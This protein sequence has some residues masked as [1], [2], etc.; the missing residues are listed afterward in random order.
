MTFSTLTA[1]SELDLVAGHGRTAHVA[2]HLGVDVELLE[3]LGEALDHVVAGLGA[4]LVGRAR[5]EHV[6]GR[7]RVGDVA[8]QRELLD[9]GR[10]RGVRGRLELAG[11]VRVDDDGGHL[12]P[13]LGL[14]LDGVLLAALP[15]LAVL[16]D[17]AVVGGVAQL[18]AVEVRVGPTAPDRLGLLRRTGLGVVP[19]PT[20]HPV[21]SGREALRHAIKGRRGDHQH[22]EEGQQHQQ[23]HHDQVG[24]EQVEQQRGDDEADS[25]TALTQRSGVAADRLRAPVGDVDESEHA[26]AERRPADHLAS[27]GSVA[28]RVAHHAP[29]DQDH[30]Q[31]HQ[32]A[33]LADRAGHDGADELEQ[34]ARRTEP[35]RGGDHDRQA[36]EEEPS[37]VATVLGVEVAGGVP[38][39][40]CGGADTV[41]DPQ[42]DGGQPPEERVEEPRYR[43]G[44]VAHGSR[45][46]PP[47]R[48][49][50]ALAVLLLR[51]PGAVA[52]AASPTFRPGRGRA[53]APR[54]RRGR[55]T[56]RHGDHT[57]AL[58]HQSH[59]PHGA[60]RIPPVALDRRDR[61]A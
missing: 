35:D 7:E 13:G 55:R 1:G 58:S 51:T 27:S 42:P 2:G 5:L 6:V 59:A 18:E 29:A 44:P 43:A 36:E 17:R 50:S 16:Q 25:S 61:S 9:A 41:G 48:G 8:G 45:R 49:R 46:R 28:D 26:E 30:E 39:T 3:H 19:V 54:S 40:A 33:D 47:L 56:G 60:C 4:R 32:P 22:A 31:R 38:D 24:A 11:G 20:E 34:P 53:P 52:R 14:G 15:A 57:R 12:E 23:R 21:A 37:T 10:D